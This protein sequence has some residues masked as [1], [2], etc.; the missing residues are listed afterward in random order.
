MR[1]GVGIAL[2]LIT[3][4]FAFGR[5]AGAQTEARLTPFETMLACAPPA[6]M[7]GAPD[8]AIHIIGAQD[9]VPRTLY[10]SRDLLVLDGGTTV[11]LQLGQRFFVRRADQFGAGNYERARTAVT[12]GWISVVAVNE[13]TAIAN[14]DHVCGPILQM[15][16]LEPYIPP[17]IPLGA[18]RTDTPGEPDFASLGRIIGGNE[19]HSMVAIGEFA[20]IDRGTE[21]GVAT[22]ARFAVYRDVGVK[23]IPLTSIGEAVIVSTAET[24]SVARIT[25]AR[26]AVLNGD[27]VAPRR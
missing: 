7:A 11:G 17:A 26:D 9:V 25:R 2:A 15:D 19:Q 13:S 23:G 3:L 10:G 24:T 8:G 14:I 6:S 27:Y 21:Q 20:L 5:A 22:G 18:D 1:R 16:Y 4:T 12:A